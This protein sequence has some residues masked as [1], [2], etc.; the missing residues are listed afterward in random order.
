MGPRVAINK[1]FTHDVVELVG[2]CVGVSFQFPWDPQRY[3]LSRALDQEMQNY[4][5]EFARPRSLVYLPNHHWLRAFP[6]SDT[7]D[8]EDFGRWVASG[9]PVEVGGQVY[10]F[11]PNLPPGLCSEQLWRIDSV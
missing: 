8:L 6:L 7:R 5:L 1:K 9:S 2:T 3:G 10:E 4:I 11:T